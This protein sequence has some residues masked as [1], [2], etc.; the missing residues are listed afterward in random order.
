M[1]VFFDTIG[2]RLNQAEIERYARQFR[3][4]GHHVVSSSRE[5]DLVI[6]N[7]CSVTS[8][9][10]SD[11][12]QKIR[13]AG[14][15]EGVRIVVTGCLATLDCDHLM[16]FP[17]VEKCISNSRKDFLSED[18]LGVSSI[19]HVE[20]KREPI[21]GNRQR[22]RA[23]IKCQDG[24]D[25]FCT[26]CITRFAR[27]QSRSISYNQIIDDIHVAEKGGAKEVVL[28]GVQLGSWGKDQLPQN[29]LTDLINHILEESTI[30]RMRLSSI[31]PWDLNDDF[32]KL[33]T[34]PRLCRQLHLPLQSGC[35]KTL[36]R[37]GRKCSPETYRG[38][39]DAARR[40]CP[41][42]AITTDIMVG[43]PG[44]NEDDFIESVAFVDSIDFAGG[45]VFN[46]SPR[47]ITPASRM[48]GQVPMSIRKS[49]SRVMRK[50]LDFSKS[51]YHQSFI[52]KTI[53]VLW[54]SAAKTMDDR[55]LLDGLTD[56]YIRVYS[57]SKEPRRN[58]I[59]RVR[60]IS[61]RDDGLFGENPQDP[62]S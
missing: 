17:F 8:E 7:T 1:N 48:T 3:A 5:A 41:E 24:C 10:A 27:G 14:R 21:P 9:A 35:G 42:I 6:I 31:E 2:C 36:E 61:A 39:V 40:E 60:L 34:N 20:E 43:F 50:I 19:L 49:R 33:W 56:N 32:F 45:H 59:D 11:S 22:T 12:R 53:D 51:N 47:S 30:P 38:Y 44:E 54:E 15:H 18:I 13:Q 57:I 58:E 52:G 23:F 55:W 4:A 29:N 26:Y 25:H 62:P 16:D 37:M 46:F 28:C